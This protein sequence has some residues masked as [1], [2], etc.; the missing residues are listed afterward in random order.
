MAN[1]QHTDE[2]TEVTPGPRVCQNHPAPLPAGCGRVRLLPRPQG[3]ERARVLMPSISPC[4]RTQQ[5]S[6]LYYL[7]PQV[8]STFLN[9]RLAGEGQRTEGVKNRQSEAWARSTGFSPWVCCGL[10]VTLDH[11]SSLW[12]SRTQESGDGQPAFPNTG[13]V[14]IRGR[15]SINLR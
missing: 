4:F 1:T 12:A 15:C 10:A 8:L 14:G 5:T 13:P 11:D 9:R 7:G 6:W 3:H 2:R